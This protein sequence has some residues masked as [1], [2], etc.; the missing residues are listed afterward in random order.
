[1]PNRPDRPAGAIKLGPD[2]FGKFSTIIT[3]SPILKVLDVSIPADSSKDF[4]AGTLIH[5]ATHQQSYTGDRINT[6]N[7]IVSALEDQKADIKRHP[8]KQA[9]V[10]C[11]YVPFL[12]QVCVH[13]SS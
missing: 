6:N 1:M 9:H 4:R 11:T 10:G 7:K 3:I 2:F 8:N 13:G 12:L 5:E